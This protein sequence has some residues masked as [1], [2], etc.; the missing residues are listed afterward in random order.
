M[1]N[2]RTS[3]DSASDLL[4]DEGSIDRAVA[5]AHREVEV[6]FEGAPLFHWHARR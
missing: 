5:M 2:R 6:F 4:R 3:S 1:I